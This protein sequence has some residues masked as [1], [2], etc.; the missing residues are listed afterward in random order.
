MKVS[1]CRTATRARPG[2]SGL[3][4]CGR[5]ICRL[6]RGR[7]Q[8]WASSASDLEADVVAGAGVLGPGVAKPDDQDAV[9]LLAAVAAAE[10]PQGL[11]PS[12]SP[13]SP[14]SPSA[15]VALALALAD[16]LG[17]LLDLGLDHLFDARRREV[18]DRDLLGVVGDEGDALGGGHGGELQGVVDLH[19]GD[20]DDDAV[21][22]VGR[23][24]FDGDLAGDVLEH[25]AGLDAGG[26][27]APS[28]SIATSAWIASLRFTC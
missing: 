25:A 18:D 5:G 24:R 16:Q 8:R 20:V 4:R 19:R 12:E 21:G 7:S 27:S 28:S 1:G 22:D 2:R 3:R 11:P 26:V 23:Q 6:A 17:F 9:A 13:E 15:A 10:Q 14:S